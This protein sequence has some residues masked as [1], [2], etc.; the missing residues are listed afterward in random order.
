MK[1]LVQNPAL[2]AAL[3]APCAI[4]LIALELVH[5]VPKGSSRTLVVVRRTLW[6]LSAISLV[7]LGILIFARF[8][9]LRTA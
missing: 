4:F 2:A 3:I 7:A 9:E 5:V 6:V 1:H 8:V